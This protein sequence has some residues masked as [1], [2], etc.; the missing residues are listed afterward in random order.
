MSKLLDNKLV[1]ILGGSGSVNDELARGL[2]AL[3]A[4]VEADLSRATGRADLVLIPVTDPGGMTPATL[5][6]MDDDEWVRRCEAPLRDMRIALQ[7]AHAVLA[8]H[9]GSIILLVPTIAMTGAAGFAPYS[10]V[11]E[12]ARS[13]A[14]AAARGWGAKG[15]TVNCL[16]LTPQQLCPDGEGQATSSKVPRALGHLPDLQT[17][18]AQFIATLVLG[19]RIVTGSTIMVDGG[20][21][22]SV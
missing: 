16:G 3:G 20:D 22:M 6:D 12:G 17:E 19:P 10:A 21:L 7:Q 13:L 18:I 1:L 11:G 15:I 5:A 8:E 2:V 9:G 4:E 14:K